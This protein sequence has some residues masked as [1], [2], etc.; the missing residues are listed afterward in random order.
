MMIFWREKK[1]NKK[2]KIHTPNST[3]KALNTI[4]ADKQSNLTK[5]VHVHVLTMGSWP[6]YQSKALQPALHQRTRED[7]TN[8]SLIDQSIDPILQNFQDFYVKQYD[9]RKLTFIDHLTTVVMTASFPLGLKEF[10]LSG[11]Q[12]RILCLFNQPKTILTTKQI[13]M[14]SGIM[15]M[16]QLESTLKSLCNV[17]S[18]TGK[19]MPILLRK[20]ATTS[21]LGGKGLGKG[22]RSTPRPFA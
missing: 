17:Y 2:K 5:K 7:Q 22:F 4:V 12:A 16:I 3:N 1:K 20:K 8:N 13:Q 11:Y 18:I 9:S 21:G 19:Q 15:D 14:A 10:T 6:D